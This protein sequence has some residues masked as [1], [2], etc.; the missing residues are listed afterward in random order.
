MAI[1]A[2][3]TD[4]GI[5]RRTDTRPIDAPPPSQTQQP[6]PP[7]L[8]PFAPGGLAP[9]RRPYQPREPLAARPRSMLEKFLRS[10]PLTLRI[11][12]PRA[13]CCEDG[14]RLRNVTSPAWNV[15]EDVRGKPGLISSEV[16]SVAYFPCPR[17]R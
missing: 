11:S 8:P 10:H 12:T 9:P 5:A 14:W 13:F 2:F 7:P 4:S 15:T 3:H 17:A 6:S 1:S 16:G